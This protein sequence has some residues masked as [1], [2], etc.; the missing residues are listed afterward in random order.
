MMTL[1]ENNNIDVYR[2]RGSDRYSKTWTK[3][4]NGDFI[5]ISLVETRQ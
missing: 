4:A 2:R 3:R 1:K 5:S